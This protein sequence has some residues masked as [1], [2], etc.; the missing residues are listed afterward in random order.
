MADKPLQDIQGSPSLGKKCGDKRDEK[1]AKQLTDDP[2]WPETVMKL[3]D[4]PPA[5]MLALYNKHTKKQNPRACL[6]PLVQEEQHADEGRQ[7]LPLRT[8]LFFL[9]A[10]AE[11]GRRRRPTSTIDD[12]GD[13][14]RQTTIDDRRSTTTTT[15]DD[16]RRGRRSTTID[17][18]RAVGWRTGRAG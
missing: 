10:G 14:R 5:W 4:V 12:G 8:V 18:R 9:V 7:L 3:A 16:D 11:G 15:T 1:L 13:R 17:V 6:R 2:L